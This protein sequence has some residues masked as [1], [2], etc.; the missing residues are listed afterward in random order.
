MAYRELKEKVRKEVHLPI[1]DF[2][3]LQWEASEKGITP[4][5]HIE[6]ILSAYTEKIEE[7]WNKKNPQH[8]VNKKTK[9]KKLQTIMKF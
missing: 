3:W 7:K 2:S 4:K 5:Q 6:N 8:Q 9:G 1:S